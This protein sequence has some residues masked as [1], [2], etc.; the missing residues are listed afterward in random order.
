METPP[1]AYL[2]LDLEVTDPAGMA[3]YREQAL[4]LVV[5]YG[6]RTIIRELNPVT[7]EGDWKPKAFVVHE[8]KDREAALRFYHSEEYA[9]LKALRNASTRSNGV[10][11]DGLS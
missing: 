6:G 11:V 3:R 4:P 7:L 9:P 8:F 5:Q 1:K 10:L 2:V